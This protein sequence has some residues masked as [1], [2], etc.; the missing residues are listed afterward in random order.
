[1]SAK[2]VFIRSIP[3]ATATGIS[4][5]VNDS[6]GRK[7]LKTKVGDRANTTLCCG[8]SRETGALGTG[9]HHPWTENGVIQKTTDGTILTLQDYYE[10]K[11]SLA[12]GYLTNRQ[13]DPRGERPLDEAKRTYF[14]DLTITLNDGTTIL[15]LSDFDD[16]MRYHAVLSHP[17][18]A[19]SEREWKD[20]KWP[21][22]EFYIAL[23][24]ESDEIKYKKN[25]IRT[26]AISELYNTNLTLPVKRQLIV[27]LGIANARTTLTEAQIHNLLF[28][29]I[30]NATGN[31]GNN[32]PKFMELVNMVATPKGRIELEAKFLLQSAIDFR[33]VIDKQNTYTWLRSTGPVVLGETYSEAIDTLTNVKKVVLVQELQDELKLK[34]D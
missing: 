29:F 31:S 6:T 23:E 1:M 3:R 5:W 25:A 16:L 8:Y 9:L 2:K 10:K 14:E 22:A 12:K 33:L 30:E 32:I 13:T 28:E 7:L 15:D 18:V 11:F 20:H 19:N 24:N 4:E 17:K 27:I 26:K 21:N 34:Q